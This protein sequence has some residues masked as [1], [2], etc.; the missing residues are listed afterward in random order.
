M[1]VLY[2]AFLASLATCNSTD[3]QRV[4]PID[5]AAYY[6]QKAAYFDSLHTAAK[7]E[8]DKKSNAFDSAKDRNDRATALDLYVQTKNANDAVNRY[9]D[10]V[11]L[12]M[13][14]AA[15]AKK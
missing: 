4:N 5:S 9:N 12:Y 7:E 14:K 1:K 10:S 2:I 3:S 15:N 6:N 8:F 11:L 13:Q